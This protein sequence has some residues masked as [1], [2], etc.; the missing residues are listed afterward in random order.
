MSV[1]LVSVELSKPSSDRPT[2][3]EVTVAGYQG[4]AITAR[5]GLQ[6]DD[7]IVRGSAL[8]ALQRLAI[9][10]DKVL[11]L[12]LRDPDWRVARRAAELAAYIATSDRAVDDALVELLCGTNATLIEV[13]AWSLGERHEE[14]VDS[15][16]VE[17]VVRSLANLATSHAEALVRE[18]AVAAL[19]S[20]GDDRG[21]VAVIA[22]TND[23]AT[24]RR[25]AVLALAAFDG[26]DVD[27]ALELAK[28]DR[29]WQ[30]RQA[31]EDLSE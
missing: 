10:N 12:A 5:R 21:R 13:A 6:S 11:V 28:R 16:L 14:A 8:S 19:G 2:R 15:P 29:D 31:A 20:I 3:L 25:R 9:L 18:A 7:P 22:A 23:K 17:S 30:V 24:V 1:G 4:D 26:P 27:A